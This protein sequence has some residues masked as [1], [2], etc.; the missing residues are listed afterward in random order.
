MFNY[1]YIANE[2]IKE[3]NRKWLQ[4]IHNPYITLIVGGSGPRE[5]KILCLI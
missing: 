5:K 4:I 2:D 1:D 3:H